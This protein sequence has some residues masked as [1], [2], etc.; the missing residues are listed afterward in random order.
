MTLNLYISIS[1]HSHV[2]YL[3]LCYV[4][5]V[6]FCECTQDGRIT[7]I[8]KCKVSRMCVCGELSTQNSH[9]VI[10]IKI[11]SSQGFRIYKTKLTHCCFLCVFYI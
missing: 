6:R 3:Y 7:G 1:I 8:E 9:R 4:V 2:P 10:A 5:A 11:K